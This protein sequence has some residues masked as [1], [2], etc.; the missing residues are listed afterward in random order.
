MN[1][2]AR[3]NLPNPGGNNLPYG[4]NLMETGGAPPGTALANGGEQTGAPKGGRRRRGRSTKRGGGAGMFGNGV[5]MGGRRRRPSRGMK[6]MKGGF[7]GFQR[8]PYIGAGTVADGNMGMEMLPSD[9]VPTPLTNSQLA[10][11]G[12]MIGGKRRR[13][14]SRKQGKATARKTRKASKGK[15]SPWLMHVMAVKK[16]N[17]SFSLGDAMKEAKKTYKK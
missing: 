15:M 16:A 2:M 14:G 6:S 11:S 5:P 7:Y 13:R 12:G 17:P 1:G 3:D 10:A 8:G 9:A 4:G